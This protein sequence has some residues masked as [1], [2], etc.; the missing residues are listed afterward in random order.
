MRL[1]Q[2]CLA[3]NL[4]RVPTRWKMRAR[5]QLF[6]ISMAFLLLLLR[7]GHKGRFL[8]AMM[9][10]EGRAP[11]IKLLLRYRLSIRLLQA[12]ALWVR[13][14]LLGLRGKAR[15]MRYDLRCTPAL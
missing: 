13:L 9:A 5:W 2:V 7:W 11:F 1:R 8:P 12:I 14:Q 4:L 15:R 6:F 3:A 10:Q